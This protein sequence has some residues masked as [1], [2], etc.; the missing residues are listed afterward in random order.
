M[1]EDGR[2]SMSLFHGFLAIVSSDL[3][4]KEVGFLSG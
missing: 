2:P 1:A 3:M 4:S